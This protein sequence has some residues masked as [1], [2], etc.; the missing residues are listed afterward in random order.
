VAVPRAG[1][2][3][4]PQQ[5]KRAEAACGLG[6]E[7]AD[8]VVGVVAES[9]VGSQPGRRVDAIHGG[10]QPRQWFEAHGTFTRMI[11]VR[12]VRVTEVDVDALLPP[13]VLPEG[14]VRR[15]FGVGQ[16]GWRPGRQ[17]I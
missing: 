4:R 2:V 7:G 3:R 13:R 12:A 17:P 16:I 9:G 5:R 15:A 11:T 1:L 14:V 8:L 6:A 10:A